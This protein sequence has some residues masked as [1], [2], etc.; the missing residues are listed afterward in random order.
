MQYIKDISGKDEQ[1]FSLDNYKRN[2][3]LLQK[4]LIK[5]P[6]VV[7]T[8]T[9]I[10]GMIFKVKYKNSFIYRMVLFLELIQDLRVVQ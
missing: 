3:F 9:T 1:G 8:G 6:Q 2:Q 10:A 5:E 7:K 4:K